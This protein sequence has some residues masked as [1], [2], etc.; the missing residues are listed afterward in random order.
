MTKRHRRQSSKM[1]ARSAPTH[2]IDT[3]KAIHR[4]FPA[5]RVLEIA[6]RQHYRIRFMP[7][8]KEVLMAAG[9][10][11]FSGRYRPYSASPRSRPEPGFCWSVS[12]TGQGY[13]FAADKPLVGATN[14]HEAPSFANFP[15]AILGLQP[16]FPARRSA[17]GHTQLSGDHG[18]NCSDYGARPDDAAAGGADKTFASAAGYLG[19]RRS[20]R[21]TIHKEGDL[22]ATFFL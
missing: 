2:H 8:I 4:K 10:S 3:V 19:I 7:I 1:A 13:Q 20:K 9:R 16:L 12:R 22:D 18:Y 6:S 5:C 15:R 14:P 21:S 11:Q 17:G